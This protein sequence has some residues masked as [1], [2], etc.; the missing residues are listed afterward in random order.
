LIA[1]AAAPVITDALP[2]RLRRLAFFVLIRWL[3]Q[4]RL[5]LTLP[6]AVILNLLLSPLCV[7]CFGTLLTFQK[8]TLK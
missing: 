8:A 5:Y 4:E 2:I 7:F 6:E 1:L 3:P